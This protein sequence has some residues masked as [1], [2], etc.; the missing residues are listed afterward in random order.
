MED[1]R[2]PKEYLNNNGYLFLL[3]FSSL[4]QSN[5]NYCLQI[6][7]SIQISRS[8]GSS[9]SYLLLHTACRHIMVTWQRQSRWHRHISHC[10]IWNILWAWLLPIYFPYSIPGNKLSLL[11]QTKIKII[12]SQQA[13]EDNLNSI[14]KLSDFL[15]LFIPS[16]MFLYVN[17]LIT[18]PVI[19]L[20][21][22]WADV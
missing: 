14:S 8:I 21:H 2:N 1:I 4:P 12:G 6:T 18:F 5:D 20:K 17:F 7:H 10:S 9:F 13:K 15:G 11:L 16:I 3:P 22:K 19:L